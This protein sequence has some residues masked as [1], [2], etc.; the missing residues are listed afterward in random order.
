MTA[1]W[2]VEDFGL[3]GTPYETIRPPMYRPEFIRRTP[4]GALGS[5]TNTRVTSSR[6]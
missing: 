6:L 1:R 2:C 5:G 3:A 4:S